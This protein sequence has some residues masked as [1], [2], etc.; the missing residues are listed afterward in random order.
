MALAQSD[1]TANV[2]NANGYLTNLPLC[3]WI[4]R[5][6]P[7]KNKHCKMRHNPD[8]DEKDRIEKQNAQRNRAL[9]DAHDPSDPFEDKQKKQLRASIFAK[10]IVEKFGIETL[11]SGAGAL[12]V[13]GGT[14]R[15]SFELLAEHV[16]I[17]QRQTSSFLILFLTDFCTFLSPKPGRHNHV[18]GAEKAQNYSKTSQTH[19]REEFGHF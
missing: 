4:I 14:G 5:G 3:K 9:N 8:D 13:A 11:N 16:R 12:D 17:A 10:W 19:E 1:P 7:C 15:L 6:V 18:G 2:S